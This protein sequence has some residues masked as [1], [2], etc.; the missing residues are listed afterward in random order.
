MMVRVLEPGV[1]WTQAFSGSLLCFCSGSASVFA[2]V[3][4][5]FSG[6]FF[7]VFACV[8]LFLLLFSSPVLGLFVPL[9]FLGFSSGFYLSFTPGFRSNPPCFLLW[10]L[11]FPPPPICSVSPPAFY[12][13]RELQKPSPPRPG[14]WQKTWS[15]WVRLCCRFSRFPVEPVFDKQ[16]TNRRILK[17]RHLAWKMTDYRLVPDV[18]KCIN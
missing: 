12:K 16:M 2:L 3:F 5:C 15:R 14:S 1:G 7:L 8:P 9:C 18:L 10:F 17:R 13:V 11:A 6:F 4:L